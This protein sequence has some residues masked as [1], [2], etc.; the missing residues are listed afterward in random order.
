MTIRKTNS[1]TCFLY[2]IIICLCSCSDKGPMALFK[3]MSPH[4]AYAQRL[5][6]AGLDRSSMG[7]TWLQK[8]EASI[9][10]AL[11][12]DIPYKETG[13]FS[14]EKIPA[15]ALRFEARRGQKLHIN[16][17]KKPSQNFAIYLDLLEECDANSRK[18]IASADTLGLLL[19]YEVKTTGKYILRLHPELLRSGEYTLSITTGPSLS[20]PVSATGKPN[21]GS[22]W[23]DG[24]DNGGRKHEGVDIFAPK[25]TPAIA[26][27]EGTVTNVTE[28]KLGGLV[29]FMHPRNRD[30]TLYYAHLDKQLVQNGQN[31]RIGDTIGLVGNTGNAR[32]TP[33]HLHFGIYT[34][35]GAIDP[36]PFVD[37]SIKQPKAI[38]AKLDL[39]NATARTTNTNTRLYVQP[40]EKAMVRTTLPVSTVLQIEAATDG[41]Y[42]ATL[43]DGTL[44]YVYNKNV[45]SAT[46]LRKAD[47]NSSR[48]LLDFPDSLSGARKITL[49][50]GQQVSIKGS[51]RNYFLITDKNDNTGWIEAER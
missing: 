39:L 17:S 11:N 27:A 51:F 12:I 16:L 23:G 50:A 14:A 10:N 47:I 48:P 15:T 33:A 19:D 40:S 18:V 5:R 46:T 41:W 37:R 21:I 30:Y 13:Y 49:A 7:S 25:L 4:D 32:T 31:V 8:S 24:R 1:L 36:L 28:N 6:D 43:P 22:F 2:F 44:G 45:T 42:K 3:K 26:A 35:G 9:T 38:S 29:V 34:N 20:F